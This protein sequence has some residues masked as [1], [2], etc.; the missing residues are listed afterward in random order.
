MEEARP[1]NLRPPSAIRIPSRYTEM[2]GEEPPGLIISPAAPMDAASLT[3]TFSNPDLARLRLAGPHQ[4]R[5]HD[6]GAGANAM[7]AL[8]PVPMPVMKANQSMAPPPPRQPKK[9]P[10]A[11]GNQ[12]KASGKRG[13][14]TT[15]TR[16]PFSEKE[17][18][19]QV[20]FDPDMI[21]W[22][23]ESEL[24]D[25][26]QPQSVPAV[27]SFAVNGISR[28]LVEVSWQDLSMA[29]RW[30]IFKVMSEKHPFA[31]V[32]S[33]ILHLTRLQTQD[34]VVNYMAQY[35]SWQKYENQMDQIPWQHLLDD[36]FHPPRPHLST[37]RI[38]L[39]DIHR[40]QDFLR[41]R[42]LDRFVDALD[43]WYGTSTGGFV[44]LAVETEIVDDSMATLQH[45]KIIDTMPAA[46]RK[47]ARLP[48]LQGRGHADQE[49][50]PQHVPGVS[51]QTF[52]EAGRSPESP[53]AAWA[54]RTMPLRPGSSLGAPDPGLSSSAATSFSS[55]V[56]GEPQP[57]DKPS[58]F[59]PIV[60]DPE[61]EPS[62]QENHEVPETSP[63]DADIADPAGILGLSPHAA[64]AMETV[65]LTRKKYIETRVS[66]LSQAPPIMRRP[67]GSWVPTPQAGVPLQGQQSAAM[68][69]P[70]MAAPTQP[71]K[72]QGNKRPKPAAKSPTKKP[73]P[74]SKKD[75][76]LDPPSKPGPSSS[77]TKN[78]AS[79]KPAAPRKRKLSVRARKSI[80]SEDLIRNPSK[81]TDNDSE[82]EPEPN[83]T[84]KRKITKK[85]EQK[86]PNGNTGKAIAI[87]PT[88]APGK[89][90]VGTDAAK[91]DAPQV[92][93]SS[94]APTANDD[95]AAN[96][97]SS[98][99]AEGE[100][101]TPP[102]QL[103][104]PFPSTI[105]TTQGRTIPLQTPP[106]AANSHLDYYHFSPCSSEAL[107]RADRGEAD[108]DTED[109]GTDTENVAKPDAEPF[110]QPGTEPDA[111]P[112]QGFNASI[113]AVTDAS[114]DVEQGPD[115]IAEPV[116][117][118]DAKRDAE[119]D[120]K[121]GPQD[122]A[123]SEGKPTAETGTEPEVKSVSEPGEESGA[124]K[125]LDTRPDAE[126]YAKSG[127]AD[128]AETSAESYRKPD[129][130]LNLELNAE[131]AK[132]IITEFG[133]YP[134]AEP[135]FEFTGAIIDQPVE[136]PVYRR[137]NSLSPSL[138]A[139]QA[140][141][142]IQATTKNNGRGALTGLRA[143]DGAEPGVTDQLTKKNPSN[144]RDGRSTTSSSRSSSVLGIQRHQTLPP[145]CGHVN[146]A[147]YA[148]CAD[149]A[150]FAADAV[151]A[152]F[153][154]R[155]DRIITLRPLYIQPLAES[156][157]RARLQA[158]SGDYD[159]AE[160]TAKSGPSPVA[161]KAM[162]A[163]CADWAIY[164]KE[165]EEAY[166]AFNSS[167]RADRPIEEM[168]REDL[169]SFGVT[170]Q[171]L[172]ASREHINGP[173]PMDYAQTQLAA[174]AS[175]ISKV[176]VDT[177]TGVEPEVPKQHGQATRDDAS[178]AADEYE[179]DE[180][181]YTRFDI[182]T[183]KPRKISD[184]KRLD[185]AAFAAWVRDSQD[186][187][188]SAA[189]EIASSNKL[190][191]LPRF[192]KPAA[193][194][195]IIAKPREYQNDLFERAKEKNII[196]VLDTG[197][198]KTLI[199]IMLVRH[200]VELE[201]QNRALGKQKKVAFFVVDKGPLC[202]QQYTA[203]NQNLEY[204]MARF[205]GA[206][207]GVTKNKAFWDEQFEKQLV[208]VCTAQILLDCLSN[209]YIRMNQIN[210]LIFDEAHHTKKNHPYARIIKQ[211]Y[212]RE[213]NECDRPRIL[214]MTASPVDAQTRDMKATAMELESLLCSK[215][216]TVPDEVLADNLARR[217]QV[218]S[219]ER[220]EEVAHP[221]DA[222][223][224][225]WKTIATIVS[226]NPQFR[227]ALDF[228]QDAGSQLGS[229]CAD[230]Y[231][232][233]QM[234]ES[235]MPK[236]QARTSQELMAFLTP[237][238]V[239]AAVAAVQ[240]VQRLVQ[241]FDLPPPSLDVSRV[242]R[243]VDSLWHT[244]QHAF[245]H[246]TERCIVFVEKRSTA[247]LLADLFT[248][249]EML[250]PGLIP[251]YLIG[252]QSTAFNFGNMSM[253]DQAIAL[254]KFRSGDIT[255]L[256]ATP[257]A[258]EGIDVPACDL[259]I[260]FDL[261]KSV[262]QYIQSKGRARQ[263]KS[264]Y[265]SMVEDGNFE[266]KKRLLQAARDA[267]ALRKFCQ[268]LPADRKTDNGQI[269]VIASAN[270]ELLGQKAFEVAATG[271]RLT[272]GNSLE[273]LARFVSSLPNPGNE[274][275]NA[276]FVVTKVGK[277]F[278]ADV[279]LPDVSPLKLIS[280]FKQQSKQLARCSAAFEACIELIDKKYLDEHLQSTYIKKINKM[281]NARLAIS[282]H[283]K[284]EYSMR[285]KPDMWSQ[286]GQEI[287]SHL[288][289]AGV[290]FSN[291]ELLE[292]KSRPLILLT[293]SQLP[294][295]PEI[296]L[297]FD[298]GG[299]KVA[300]L[301]AS[302]GS[303]SFDEEEV[304]ALMHFTLKVFKDVF[305]K[306]YEATAKE[307]PYFMVPASASHEGLRAGSP[308]ELDWQLIRQVNKDDYLKWEGAPDSFFH[309][310]YVIDPHDGGRR[311]VLHGIN[312]GLKPEDPVPEGVPEPKSRAWRESDRSIKEYSNSMWRRTRK[313]TEWR[314]GQ[315]VV[316][317]E[318][319]P[320]RRNLLDELAV[321]EGP[322]SSR[323]CFLVLQTLEV[324]PLPVDVVAMTMTM[325]AILH[326]LESILIAMDACS[327]LSLQITPSLAL[328][329]MTKDSDNTDE[330]GEQ[331]VNFQAG[332][333]HNYERLEFLGDSFL[334]MA[335]TIS[336]FT[337]IPDFDESQYHDERMLMVCNQNL[338]NHAVDRKLYEY[339]RSRSFDRRTWYPNLKLIKGKAPKLEVRHQLGD[340][341]IA[342]VCEALIGAAYL[343]GVSH[344]NIDMAVA[345][346]SCMVKNKK[347]AMMTFA[348][349]YTS[350]NVPD[351]HTEGATAAQNFAVEQI[352]KTIG[353]KFQSGPLLR[354]AF[355][356]PSY[357]FESIPHYQRLE[358]LGDALLDMAI[359]DYLFKHFP[360]AD[361]QWL[362]E[363]KMAIASNQFLGCLCVKLDLHRHLLRSTSSLNGQIAQYIT[364]LQQA[365]EAAQTEGTTSRNATRKDFWVSAP[366]PPKALSD[367][368]EA[369]VGAM[370]VDAKYDYSVV[371]NFFDR[372]VQPYFADME[373]YDTF[374]NKH[375]V[376]EL[377]R[378]LTDAGCTRWRLCATN[379]PCP[380]EDG[381][382]AVTEN[383]VVCAL[384][385]H[386][387]VV[388][389]TVA[390]SGRYGKVRLAKQALAMVKDWSTEQYKQETGCDCQGVKTE[391]LRLEDHGTAV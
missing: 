282:P 71:Q 35:H 365:E 174:L 237:G 15:T 340:K 164:A 307:I 217:E 13:S 216:A 201:L 181:D 195:K 280:G 57:V 14:A 336:L 284:A 252:T 338:F 333:G 21:D 289:K 33:S 169:I 268:E 240:Q 177:A 224:D 74:A 206:M 362:T 38:A 313:N 369:L 98:Q 11:K 143:G 230:R 129:A 294:D 44:G 111:E 114:H 317:A 70:D 87:E 150:T 375:P 62:S 107:E 132:Y 346:V 16:P 113:K 141:A 40:G 127:A 17:L 262:I 22:G 312:A 121:S 367:M 85:V 108:G 203:L 122:D 352:A 25:D 36:Q 221:E 267:Q 79:K 281:R 2:G 234:T 253:R 347:H 359:V 219:V 376:T 265:I 197:S 355:K 192:D 97:S 39:E 384:L 272:F 354:S 3:A 110:K 372:F 324:S 388:A 184:K 50:T 1:H 31:H 299:A 213:R 259:I 348:E 291:P 4:H 301:V 20:L 18:L 67:A 357:T 380:V 124:S 115:P 165:A 90:T 48:I 306:K 171:P 297:F 386:G 92:V 128:G 66:R 5:P 77:S 390:K 351:W 134:P 8:H 32:S 72:P 190:E 125:D 290:Y 6:L 295:V 264:R 266:H 233:L 242:S 109:R 88:P 185:S 391:E 194:M 167:G 296:P 166:F 170:Q 325:P 46:L 89:E 215:I 27:P 251:A 300:R 186:E 37:D 274:H 147:H 288:F 153:A 225:L 361:P 73:P 314:E 155:T 246:G 146:E 103:V 34:F 381:I 94:L 126:S 235:E 363:H 360:K 239:D 163:G 96:E 53:P 55:T 148:W 178:D 342:D 222:R 285:L 43:D 64:M 60:I 69:P 331:Q 298:S 335:T 218:E 179:A 385:V 292:R 316:N 350:F 149:A 145:S 263:Q 322:E 387:K 319:L 136:E 28:P 250:I 117:D 112:A 271:A 236:L 119:P 356:H 154:A 305:N 202:S 91:S 19:E 75:E 199:G 310:K 102:R 308:L 10:S 86:K 116:A 204:P 238:E 279:I 144:G 208:I 61:D 58:T 65:A 277:K 378:V 343:D 205:Y 41:G 47:G 131:Y 200:I 245:T 368:V 118:R 248:Q 255:C 260:R 54:T 214:G 243:K 329:A 196:V 309:G 332:M 370:F 244:L 189:K 157:M 278:T 24:E 7:K 63:W 211:H 287:P 258:E 207:A 9:A 158:F 383:D 120:A 311:F 377:A 339:I 209:G 68:R 30:I 232:K 226:N 366:Q 341:S 139:S 269:D 93:T 337:L 26:E 82:Y 228:A 176:A 193:D 80:E 51:V 210:L 330:H 12:A 76:K 130:D 140:Q 256:F 353:Y 138:G 101:V 364:D 276:E 349:Y 105:Q 191:A 261:Y 231:W 172:G 173:C 188:A 104:D 328:E 304:E 175:S 273:V 358:F 151:R 257:I 344:G 323:N 320:L 23:S 283:K 168:A 275:L 78:P 183:A 212:L 59:Q 42:G 326:R 379:V 334:K 81:L 315:P 180:E 187:I 198:G 56:P 161:S 52:K 45:S 137:N 95:Q 371:Q 160:E 229:W 123:G 302:S 247:F 106:S 133:G 84:K 389:H 182:G 29:T 318:L 227:P 159:E 156:E 49:Q 241:A 382:A 374:A 152:Q 254:M 142:L 100:V 286:L 293:R 83:A 223:T 345:A 270:Y 220:Y 99:D 162:F 249:R 373:L 327:L 303:R 321:D 135:F